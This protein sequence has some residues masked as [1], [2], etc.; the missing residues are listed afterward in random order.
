MA[1]TA[2]YTIVGRYMDG[3]SVTGYHLLDVNGEQRRV[4]REQVIFLVGK[5]DISNCRGQ[6]HKDDVILRGVGI[7]LNDLPV[8]NEN[9]GELKNTANLGRV[10]RGATTEQALA[11]FMI[12]G[13]IIQGNRTI[14]FTI[15]NAGGATK[16]ISREQA[17][18]LAGRLRIGNARLQE[19]KGRKII[20]LING[21][22]EDLPVTMEVPPPKEGVKNR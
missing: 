4:T 9:T 7:N 21:K 2:R 22:M 10:A 20:R 6:L 17:E 16:D 15:A 8:V 11:Q 19:Y 3:S 5:G 12:V 1:G 18:K 14:G 13:K